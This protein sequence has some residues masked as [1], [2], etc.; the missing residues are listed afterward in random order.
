[1]ARGL[2]FFGVNLGGIK[3]IAQDIHGAVLY[4]DFSSLKLG[5]IRWLEDCAPI[6]IGAVDEIARHYHP[7]SYRQKT[8]RNLQESSRDR[9]GFLLDYRRN[10]SKQH[11]YDNENTDRFF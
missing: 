8:S 3:D 4:D 9:I 7:I 5:I 2:M 10:K 1:M 6:A 11:N